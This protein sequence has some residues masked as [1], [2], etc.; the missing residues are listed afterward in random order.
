MLR[1]DFVKKISYILQNINKYLTKKVLI[2]KPK[3]NIKKKLI[4]TGAHLLFNPIEGEIID[5]N[6]VPYKTFSGKHLG[7]GFAIKPIGNKVFSPVNCKVAF[8]FPTK[9]AIVISTED[10]LEILIHIGI[11][12]VSLNGEG[13]TVHVEKD[14]QIKQGDLLITFDTKI[15]KEKGKNLISCVVITNKS[16]VKNVAINYGNKKAGEKVAKIL[17]V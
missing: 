13:F 1:G 14:S 3:E 4:F 7:D 11:N 17:L 6:E 16:M 15:I 12:T 8:I 9:H 2:V 10:G 5:L